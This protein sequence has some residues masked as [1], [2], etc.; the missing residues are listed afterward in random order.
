MV[1][2]SSNGSSTL[3]SWVSF[4]REDH[5]GERRPHG[6][7]ENRAHADQRP[8]SGA[9][10]RAGTSLPRRP[11][12]PPIISSGAS[13]PPEVP[14]PS[15]TAQITDFTSRIPSNHRSRHVALQ[16]RADGVVADAQRLREDQPAQPDHQAA[17]RRPPHP[18]DRQLPE[19]DLPPHTLP[20]S[21][22]HERAAG[23]QPGQRHNP[24][25]PCGPMKSVCGGTGNSGPSPRM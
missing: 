17:D 8:E 9:L 4:E 14:E 16:Q 24:P 11:S 18:V 1:T 13:T 25:A 6:P 15:E 5:A 12:A 23:Q 2:A 10:V 19:R 21:A 20:A 3:I 7:A 22:A